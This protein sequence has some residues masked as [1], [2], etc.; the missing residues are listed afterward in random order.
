[1]RR[2]LLISNSTMHGRQPLEHVLDDLRRFLGT[3]RELLFVPWALA[4]HDGYAARIRAAFARIDVRVRSIH[5]A[6]NALAAVG[7]A[8]AVFVGGGNTF[9]LLDRLQRTGTAAAIAAR[10]LAGMPYVGSSAGT[11]VATPTIRT[12]N[13]M[14]IVEPRSFAAMA[15]VPFQINAHYLDPDPH[16][17]HMGETR[18]ERLRQFHEEHDT[19]VLGLREGNWLCVDGERMEL[20]GSTRARLFRRGRDPE[21]FTPVADLSFLLQNGVR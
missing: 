6:T 1:M 14:P 7:D 19:P 11:G 2:L 5:E 13:D 18:E 10:A 12:T 3:V 15:L 21:E 8:E 4:D 20:R 16:S 9:R 17:T